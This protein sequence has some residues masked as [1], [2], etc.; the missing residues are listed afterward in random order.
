MDALKA[1]FTDDAAA[2]MLIRH[3]GVLKAPARCKSKVQPLDA[4]ITKPFRSILREC[5]EDHVVKV[6]VMGQDI[7]NEAN[8]NP[9][10]KLSYPTRQDIIDW[11]LLKHAI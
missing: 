4:C 2:V 10:F 8:N 9:S 11:V 6:V 7:G 1:H 3:S 5:W